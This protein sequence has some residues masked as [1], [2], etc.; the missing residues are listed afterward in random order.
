M[1]LPLASRV[2]AHACGK[3]KENSSKI[4]IGTVCQLDS[5]RMGETTTSGVVPG[6]GMTRC[7]AWRAF[8]LFA[9]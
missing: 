8:W 2:S 9:R 1:P 4:K 5:S 7:T 3:I 6:K